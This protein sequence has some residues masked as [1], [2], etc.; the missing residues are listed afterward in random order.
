MKKLI[1][2]LACLGVTAGCSKPPAAITMSQ[3][4]ENLAVTRWSDKTEL[5]ME[6]PPLVAGT[7][8]RLT[9][10]VT[11]LRTFKPITA[12][13][14]TVQ[15]KQND[16]GTLTFSAP[17][18]SRRGIF[19][20]DLQSPQPGRYSM[21]V[22]LRSPGLDDRHELGEVAV[23]ATQTEIPPEPHDDSTRSPH[24]S[25]EPHDDSAGPHAHSTEPDPH[26][27]E[28]D[29]ES[30]EKITFLKEQQ[31]T[32]DFATAL[33]AERQIRES[34]RVP[35]EVRP[36]SGGE[37]E[38]TAPISGRLAMSTPLPV[39]GAVV[40]Q[41]QPLASLIPPTPAPAD[42]P[43]LESALAETT[44]AFELARLD[45]ERAERLA[46]GGS[47]SC[48]ASP[49]SPGNGGHGSS[50]L[51]GGKGPSGAIRIHPPG[52]CDPK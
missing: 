26:P 24:D 51:E 36:R 44:T 18:P 52:R 28:P 37:V 29:Q 33:V 12:G 21:I 32:L 38:V 31:W 8:A 41:G 49:G 50:P 45:R 3:E 13:Q 40:S 34:L 48:P 19:G 25:T 10:H 7:E 4:P 43:A 16:G 15:L 39:I 9:I 30:E 22:T 14:L 46:G 20:V 35:A 11:D 1:L 17:S 2:I 5:F 23:Y 6:Y 42:L 27:T 47:S